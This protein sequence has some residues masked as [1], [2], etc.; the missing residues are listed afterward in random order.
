MNPLG[1]EPQATKKEVVETSFFVIRLGL[2]I[3]SSKRFHK[4]KRLK[5]PLGLSLKQQKK[6][7]LRPLFL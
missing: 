2:V 5:E 6:R 1:F 4:V 7:S 3:V